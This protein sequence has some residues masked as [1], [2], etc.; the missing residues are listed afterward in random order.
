MKG[1][2]NSEDLGV[3]GRIILEWIFEKYAKVWTECIWLKIGKMAKSYGHIMKFR[4]PLKVGNF[5]TS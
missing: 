2:D 3:D 4:V 5:L 1:R